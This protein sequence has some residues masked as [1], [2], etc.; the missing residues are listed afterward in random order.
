MTRETPPELEATRR[1]SLGPWNLAPASEGRGLVQPVPATMAE[2]ATVAS[3]GSDDV[4][5]TMGPDDPA[6]LETL[7]RRRDALA[8]DHGSGEDRPQAVER[9]AALMRH[10]ASLSISFVLAFAWLAPAALAQRLVESVP[11]HGQSAPTSI[12]VIALAGRPADE[13]ALLRALATE[14]RDPFSYST[15]DIAVRALVSIDANGRPLAVWLA[16]ALPQDRFAGVVLRAL[17][18]VH[19]AGGGARACE[20]GIALRRGEMPSL[21][22]LDDAGL[23]GRLPTV[24]QAGTPA[25]VPARDARVSEPRVQVEPSRRGPIERA[26]RRHPRTIELCYQAALQ[27]R[28]PLVGQGAFEIEVVTS[29]EGQVVSVTAVSDPTESP[30]FADC[31]ALEVQ[32]W[33]FPA[34]ATTASFR[35]RWTLRHRASPP[36]RFAPLER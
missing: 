4:A 25:W 23:A 6:T 2:S 5:L 27:E 30:S 24:S 17:A 19:L 18:S 9:G 36:R 15:G 21:A 16:P 12:E 10:V 14:L 26:V 34:S 29:P 31:V 33:T 28:G 3:Q 1:A 11:V 20:I 13:R 7:A 35:V 8:H 22:T 32:A